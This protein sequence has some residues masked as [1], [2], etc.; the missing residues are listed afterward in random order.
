MEDEFDLGVWLVGY[1]LVQI[2]P[3]IQKG[4]RALTFI[5]TAHVSQDLVERRQ[6]LIG[7]LSHGEDPYKRAG[8]RAAGLLANRGL[9]D[10]IDLGLDGLHDLLDMLVVG[11]LAVLQL[12]DH[13]EVLGR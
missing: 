1:E 9:V 12:V 8:L 11:F 10:D 7:M 5:L 2:G 3:G 4:R 13:I 6:P